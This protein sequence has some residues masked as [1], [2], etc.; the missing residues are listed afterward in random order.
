MRDDK[1]HIGKL[2]AV[3]TIVLL[4]MIWSC[5]RLPVHAGD[6]EDF[7]AERSQLLVR[8]ESY[9]EVMQNLK[10]RISQLDA[11]IEYVNKKEAEKT[12]EK[13]KKKSKKKSKKK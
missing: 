11:L 9:D 10:Y 4:W 2:V 3:A 6:I 7:Q 5:S 13:E 12:K 1:W 8:L